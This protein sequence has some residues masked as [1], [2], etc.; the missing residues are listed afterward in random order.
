MERS[1]N[2]SKKMEGVTA[3]ERSEFMKK[4]LDDLK[5]EG[6]ESRKKMNQEIAEYSRKLNEERRNRQARQ[7]KLAFTLSRRKQTSR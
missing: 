4:Y 2:F 7:E 6:E 1:R 3:A 5:K